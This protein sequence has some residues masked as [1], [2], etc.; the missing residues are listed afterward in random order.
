MVVLTGQV[1]TFKHFVAV[2]GYGYGHVCE[3]S[4]IVGHF[5]YIRYTGLLL[6][7]GTYF[8]AKLSRSETCILYANAVQS[9]CLIS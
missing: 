3:G 1:G 5:M 6:L 9:K 7:F 8:G 2:V 4:G